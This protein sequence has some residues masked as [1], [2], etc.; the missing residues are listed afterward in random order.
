MFRIDWGTSDLIVERA[1]KRGNDIAYYH[2][3]TLLDWRT[4]QD[5]KNSIDQID[6]STGF[7]T[8]GQW[9]IYLSQLDSDT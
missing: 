3:M 6:I 9:K 2:W 5:S 4:S 8:S 7:G 1:I